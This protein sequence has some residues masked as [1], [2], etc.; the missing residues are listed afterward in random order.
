MNQAVSTRAK[1]N[2]NN[3]KYTFQLA[4]CLESHF[5]IYSFAEDDTMYF[6]NWSLWRGNTK[7]EDDGK[8][9]KDQLTCNV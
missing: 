1:K 9:L 8:R 4:D 3:T 7:Q 2:K 6:P 5:I